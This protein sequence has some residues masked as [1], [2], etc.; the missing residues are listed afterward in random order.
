MFECLNVRMFELETTWTTGKDNFLEVRGLTRPRSFER[1]TI[2]SQR[3]E[4]NVKFSGYNIVVL[5]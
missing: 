4:K 5:F 3:I 1:F 2:R